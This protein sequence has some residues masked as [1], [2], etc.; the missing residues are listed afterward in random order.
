MKKVIKQKMKDIEQKILEDKKEYVL[1]NDNFLLSL[2]GT[3]DINGENHWVKIVE[4]P[5]V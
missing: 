5:R 3:Q 2:V 4:I 1:N